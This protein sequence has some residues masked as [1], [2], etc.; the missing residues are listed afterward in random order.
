MYAYIQIYFYLS[1]YLCRDKN[2]VYQIKISAFMVFYCIT[3][4]LGCIVNEW[5][6]FSLMKINFT[7]TTLIQNIIEKTHSSLCICDI[8]ANL[9]PYMIHPKAIKM[10]GF[11]LY[12][13]LFQHIPK[14]QPSPTHPK[15]SPSCC[16]L[17]SRSVSRLCST[18]S[19]S[20]VMPR[21]ITRL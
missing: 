3:S 8:H 2:K 4:N 9:F 21:F 1:V 14:G 13:C 7:P 20:H 11:C 19:C 16:F 15:Q 12:D 17:D 6:V 10:F 18:R 5:L